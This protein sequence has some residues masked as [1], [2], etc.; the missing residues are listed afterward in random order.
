LSTLNEIVDKLQEMWKTNT[1]EKENG[2]D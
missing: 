2:V 1:E